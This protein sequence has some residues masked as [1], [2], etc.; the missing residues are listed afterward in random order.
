M[1]FYACKPE[2]LPEPIEEEPSLKVLAKLGTDSLIIAAGKDD[3][4]LES[5]FAK[6]DFDIYTFSGTFKKSNCSTTCTE[7]LTIRL[8]D[9]KITKPGANFIRDESLRTGMYPIAD[10][11]NPVFLV[12]THQFNTGNT[13]IV[14]N[15]NYQYLWIFNGLDSATCEQ[16]VF[17]FPGTSGQTVELI[18]TNESEGCTDVWQDD[19]KFAL[20]PPCPFATFSYINQPDGQ[21]NFIL[22]F[23]NVS[24]ISSAWD[25]GDNMTSQEGAISTITHT[26]ATPGIYDV[27]VDVELI[28]G[29][30]GSFCSRVQSHQGIDCSAGFDYRPVL[31][32]PYYFSSIIFDWVSADGELYS[33][34][35][36]S[37]EQQP[38]DSFFEIL[39]IEPFIDDLDGQKT[40]KITARAKAK[41][42][43]TSDFSD[44]IIFETEELVFAVAYP[45]I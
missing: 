21:V 4:Y 17:Y 38:A 36:D 27:C 9:R 18:L 29:C 3:Y 31:P 37:F 23:F 35:V 11:A 39:S 19:V 28:G 7:E 5:D 14:D 44:S 25:F 26:Y 32:E 30:S 45:D 34:F 10:F 13:N 24:I 42:F 33:S 2:P 16:P 40:M 6:D 20:Q 43:N 12:Q 15:P 22:P 1:F 8:R 41:L